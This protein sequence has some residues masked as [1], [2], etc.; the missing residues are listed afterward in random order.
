M[1]FIF[2]QSLTFESTFVSVRDFMSEIRNGILSVLK[3]VSFFYQT[4]TLKTARARVWA[5]F[6]IR[7]AS[8]EARGAF[9]I[10][11]TTPY[12]SCFIERTTRLTATCHSKDLYIYK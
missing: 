1:G 8:L 5:A 10:V 9:K 3:V 11:A 12:I 2:I 6:K 7:A 4:V